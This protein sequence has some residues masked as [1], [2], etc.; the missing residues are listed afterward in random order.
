MKILCILGAIIITV[1]WTLCAAAG[2]DDEANG[3]K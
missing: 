1:V 2:M 3:R